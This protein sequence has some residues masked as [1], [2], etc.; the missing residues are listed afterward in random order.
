M[1]FICPSQRI[2]S[3]WDKL[4]EIIDA[5]GTNYILIGEYCI[6]YEGVRM[7]IFSWN[8][9]LGALGLAASKKDPQMTGDVS[10]LRGFCDRIERD[11]F[12]P[13]RP[14]ELSSQTAREI[15]RYYQVIDENNK[16][17]ESERVRRFLSTIDRKLKED[18]GGVMYMA[19]TPKPYATLDELSEDLVRQ[20][21]R[22]IN[23]Y[24][25]MN[26]NR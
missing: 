26:N 24:K 25:A 19:L 21:I 7:S 9:L 16:W 6:E 14:E 4:V 10:Q 17:V 2:V 12:V 13:F 22:R 18:F 8:E 1:L 23:E 15:D 20:I 11:A 3:L 5:D